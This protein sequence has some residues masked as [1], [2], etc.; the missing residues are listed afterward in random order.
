[1][2]FLKQK[3]E[4]SFCGEFQGTSHLLQTSSKEY[5]VCAFVLCFEI[6]IKT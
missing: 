4:K 1:M 6:E 5:M 2:L 3:I